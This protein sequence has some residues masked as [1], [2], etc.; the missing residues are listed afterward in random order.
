MEDG[1]EIDWSP[2]QHKYVQLADHIEAQIRDGRLAPRAALPSVPRLA[3]TYGVAKMTASRA[4]K[5]LVERGLVVVVFG[6]GTFVRDPE[7]V[8]PDA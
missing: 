8:P 3:E 2:L 4:V 1:S 7:D 5:V 6:R